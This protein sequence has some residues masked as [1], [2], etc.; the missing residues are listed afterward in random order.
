[1]EKDK[2]LFNIDAEQSVLGT[3][4]L[5][6]DYLA[7]VIEILQP[8]FFY[9]P[10]H[11]KIYEYIINTTLKSNISS[12]SVTLKLFFDNDDDLNDVGGSAYLTKLLK[13]GAGIV[14]ITD[15]ANIIRDL[16]VKRKIVFI[17]EDAIVNTYKNSSQVNSNDLLEKIEGDFFTLSLMGN[18]DKTFV[19]VASTARDAVQKI[20]NA[21]NREGDVS[22]IPSG[23][24]ELDDVL[25]GFQNSN[26]IIIGGRPGMGKSALVT[27]FAHSASLHLLK[28]KKSVGIFSLEMSCE[29]I[30]ERLLAMKTRIE[31]TRFR[32]GKIDKTDFDKILMAQQDLSKLPIF[33]DETGS[34][35]IATLKTRARRMIKQK[36]MGLM[37]VD[38]LQLMHGVTEQ[39]RSSKV[40]EIGEITM[41]LKAM[42]KEFNIPIIVLSQ[43]S[44]A[45]EKGRPDKKPQL[46]DLR[47]SGNIEQD[48]DIVMF[49]HREEY[50]LK[51][52]QPP[53]GDIKM[54]EWQ[55]KM[56]FV[57]NKTEILVA[58]HRNGPTKNITIFY[59]E[60]I[61]LFDD[62]DFAHDNNRVGV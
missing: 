39:A 21:I 11:Q 19:D 34:L 45:P 35:S 36:K 12:D 52:E 59:D 26:L 10:I 14:D 15:Y 53:A 61:G 9:E 40:L 60:S 17:S 58:K 5:N 33:I 4:I 20:E 57:K 24:N 29:E 44:R 23:I 28:E 43:L 18:N 8:I 2:K 22:G 56:D 25:G 38:Y 32:N 1:M 51:K 48:A 7:K 50:Y 13:I 49:I 16:A 6:N 41:G 46:A 27:S 55:N 31:T 47:D 30:V 37:I 62:Y 54:Q 3:I 42:A